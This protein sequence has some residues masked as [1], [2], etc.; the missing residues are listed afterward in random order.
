MLRGHLGLART[1]LLRFALSALLGFAAAPAVAGASL[2]APSP[3]AVP[4]GF[5]GMNLD[6]PMYPD[7]A[8]GID[9]AQ[10]FTAIEQ[11]GVESVRVTFGWSRAQPYASWSQ[12]P[13]PG[14]GQFVNV[15]GIPTDFQQLDELVGLAA[16]HGITVL[17][18]VIYAPQWDITGASSQ[19][20]GR[21]ATDRPY[22]AFLTALVD[23]Y[24][25]RGS[26]WQGYSPPA[27]PIRTWEIW[28]EPNIDYFWPAQPFARSYV[29]L[30]LAASKAIK[31]ADPGARVMLGGL[32]NYSWTDLASIYR[33]AGARAA[34]DVVGLHPYTAT[35]AG[36]ITIT[37]YVRRV[38][39]AN[40]DAAKPIIIDEVGWPASKGLPGG[41]GGG[42]G[43][44]VAGQAR[45]T[46]ALLPLLARDRVALN[47]SAFDYYTWAGAK[48]PPSA[49]FSEFSFAG[50]FDYIDGALVQ[51]PAFAAFAK[52]ALAIERCRR[53]GTLASICAQPG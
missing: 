37:R 23:R 12:V 2:L 22:A 10:Q 8:A 48:L 25:P 30:L 51:K 53:K 3:A 11:A 46:A 31:A 47:V 49:A 50:L 17:P 18:T 52:A 38:M 21:P 9:L 43:T 42:L 45:N 20:I 19:S 6:G 1:A 27:E 4:D 32:P 14:S 7:T 39:D 36:V 40:H 29:A 5:V 41:G 24:G 28:N 26:F 13:A 33:V 15:G 44:T 35:P 16:Q 34:F